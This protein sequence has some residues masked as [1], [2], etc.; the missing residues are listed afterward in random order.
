M[1]CIR[2]KPLHTAKKTSNNV[3]KPPREREKIFAYYASVMFTYHTDAPVLCDPGDRIPA[4]ACYTMRLPLLTFVYNV[5]LGNV[6][7]RND[8]LWIWK[9]WDLLNVQSRK[10][11]QLL[12][13]P[14][15]Q[16]KVNSALTK[17]ER[18]QSFTRSQN[19]LFRC[20]CFAV[21]EQSE[22]NWYD[23]LQIC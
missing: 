6:C 8:K 22:R 7:S 2:L 11:Y 9:S 5:A 10:P 3:R 21:L 15:P 12:K 19:Q 13:S 17:R 14:L 18:C 1:D 4:C 23:I 16:G 20:G